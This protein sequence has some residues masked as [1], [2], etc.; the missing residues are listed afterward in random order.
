MPLKSGKP[1]RAEVLAR[2][3]AMTLEKDI[4]ERFSTTILSAKAERALERRGITDLTT[5]DVCKRLEI[6]ELEAVA[7]MFRAKS[8]GTAV[9]EDR[10][11]KALKI[12]GHL[13]VQIA[14][15]TVENQGG[16]VSFD[17]EKRA[18]LENLRALLMADPGLARRLK[19][20]KL[21]EK[22]IESV[23]IQVQSVKKEG[24]NG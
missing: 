18:R 17:A 14:A 23:T 6:Y 9:G 12:A 15:L 22:A 11:L 3:H 19:L 20:G 4:R 8:E 21:G 16:S 2:L 7:S 13:A 5:E 10:A 24:E 1:T